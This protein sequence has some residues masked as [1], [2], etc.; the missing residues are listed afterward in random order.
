[1]N[2]YGYSIVSDVVSEGFARGLGRFTT[3][4]GLTADKF[5]KHKRGIAQR[6]SKL[7]NKNVGWGA[8]N[9]FSR[10]FEAGLKTAPLTK[11]GKI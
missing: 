10:D 3:H 4:L 7:T 11:S 1:M 8:P 5:D 9:K 2:Q 6:L